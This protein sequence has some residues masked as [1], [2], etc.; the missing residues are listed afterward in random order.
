MPGPSSQPADRDTELQLVA[1][2]MEMAFNAFDDRTLTDRETAVVFVHT[3][4]LVG[5]A[6]KGAAAGGIISEEQRAE[7]AVLIEGMAQAPRLV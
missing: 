2:E 5:H 7:L 6:L 3:L 1:E 4:N